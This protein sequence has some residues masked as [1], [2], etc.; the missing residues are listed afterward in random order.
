[1]FVV[2]FPVRPQYAR[3]YADLA[4]LLVR[5]GR[6]DLV[7]GVGLDDLADPVSDGI[8]D[9]EAAQRAARLTADLERMGPTYIKFGQLLSTRVDLLPPA[10]TEALARL[11]D[12]VEPF[13]FAEV[14]Q[15]VVRELGVS[16]SHG[17]SSFD[18]APLAAA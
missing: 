17:F 15:I 11:Q 13:P 7:T 12:D 1:M 3:Q 8:V 2:R 4:R 9:E 6:S 5:Y 18:E 16:L 14:E 10:Y